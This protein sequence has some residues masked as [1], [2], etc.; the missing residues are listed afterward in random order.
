MNVRAGP[1]DGGDWTEG[2]LGSPPFLASIFRGFAFAAFSGR[3]ESNEDRHLP[4]N[5]SR[6]L[7]VAALSS[8]VKWERAKDSSCS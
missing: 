4:P 7:E 2:L 8:T 3:N 5:K 6:R 1:M